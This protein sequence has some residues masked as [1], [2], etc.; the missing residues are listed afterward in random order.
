VSD[1]RENEILNL[2]EE[3]ARRGKPLS[4]AKSYG[5]TQKI[6][7]NDNQQMVRSKKASTVSQTIRGDGNV[8]QTIITEKA[9]HVKYLPPPGSIGSDGFLKQRITEL[10]NRIAEARKK[11]RGFDNAHAVVRAQLKKYLDIRDNP[12]TIIWQWPAE[13]AD[14]IIAYL[15]D[16]YE[17]TIPGKI[18]TASRR[19]GYIPTRGRLYEKEVELLEHFDLKMDSPQVKALLLQKFGVES[20]GKLTHAQQLQWVSFLEHEVNQ[21]EGS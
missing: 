14:K 21:I 13:A 9:P 2:M 10:L 12:W 16:T 18:K 1:D 4:N 15:E 19:E 17:K 5:V 7:G 6:K 11:T 8:Q 20:H 3:A